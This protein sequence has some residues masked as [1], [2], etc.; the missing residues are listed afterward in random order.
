METILYHIIF[1]IRFLNLLSF[2]LDNILVYF[3][4]QIQ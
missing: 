2:I 1:F 4:H 3:R